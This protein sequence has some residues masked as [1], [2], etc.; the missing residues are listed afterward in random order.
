[1]LSRY[2][3]FFLFLSSPFWGV[4]VEKAIEMQFEK[5]HVFVEIPAGFKTNDTKE[6]DSMLLN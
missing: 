6:A 3:V 5:V 2:N 4:S 1:M